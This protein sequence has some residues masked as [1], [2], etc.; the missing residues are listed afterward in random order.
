MRIF[1]LIVLLLSQGC[2]AM[3]LSALM[4]EDEPVVVE[5]IEYVKQDVNCG[6]TPQVNAIHLQDYEPIVLP[7]LAAL[8]VAIENLPEY[9][10]DHYDHGWMA[11]SMADWE[12]IDT[13]DIDKMRVT[14]Q[15]K[16]VVE[17]YEKCI[18]EYSNAGK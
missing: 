3:L 11:L 6:T 5:K 1:L 12:D 7:S 4:N 9:L 2:A 16:K 18:E 14:L 15:W 13:N 17:F 8:G 10:V